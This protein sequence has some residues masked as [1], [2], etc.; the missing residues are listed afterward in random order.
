MA[1]QRR[2][3]GDGSMYVMD[4]TASSLASTSPLNSV[5]LIFL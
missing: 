3:S 5:L 2:F 1:R 4:D